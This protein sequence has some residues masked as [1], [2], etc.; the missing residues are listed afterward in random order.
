MQFGG[1]GVDHWPGKFDLHL[2][3]R[4][5]VLDSLIAA[6]RLAK[7]LAAFGIF[8]GQVDQPLAEA[9]ELCRCQQRSTVGAL[10]PSRCR[11]PRA[12]GR[13]PIHAEQTTEGIDA[14]HAGQS[15]GV[16][17]D[18]M[19]SVAIWENQRDGSIGVG[20]VAVGRMADSHHFTI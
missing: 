20:Y 16:N 18:Q 8:D 19:K 15:D 3:G 6:D 13:G 14:L 2:C 4:Q 5:L 9:D 7:L 10:T 1:S 17:V 12:R 11:N